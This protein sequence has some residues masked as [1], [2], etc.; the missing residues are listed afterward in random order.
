MKKKKCFQLSLVLHI[1]ERTSLKM[2]TSDD[3]SH[4]E[5]R[6]LE[7]NRHFFDFSQGSSNATFEHDATLKTFFTSFDTSISNQGAEMSSEVWIQ[8]G[9]NSSTFQDPDRVEIFRDDEN[10]LP[11]FVHDFEASPEPCQSLTQKRRGR[12]PKDWNEIKKKL[13]NLHCDPKLHR[14][15]KNNLYSAQYRIKKSL[16]EYKKKEELQTMETKTS[17]LARKLALLKNTRKHLE[18]V[19]QQEFSNFSEM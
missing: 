14:K 10:I 16:I 15:L 17:S 2:T 5:K 4:F 11:L 3:F 18:F 12:K 7:S 1:V 19:Q 8:K 9:I 6:E 13:S